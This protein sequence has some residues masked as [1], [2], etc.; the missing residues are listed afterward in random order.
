M[1]LCPHGNLE[2]LISNNDGIGEESLL[3][4]LF[5]Q[6]CQG[7]NAL[8]TMTGYVHMDLKCESILIGSDLQMKVCDFSSAL[9]LNRDVD[10][11]SGVDYQV[12]SET[13]LILN[14][15]KGIQ[16]DILALGVIL[17]TMKFAIAPFSKAVRSDRNFLIL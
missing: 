17:F 6:I 13:K 1:E 14:K 5:T 2:G 12:N 8:H 4:S 16:I 7:V 9:E 10:I 11:S 3:K 15:Q